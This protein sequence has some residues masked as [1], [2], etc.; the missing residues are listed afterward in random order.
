VVAVILTYRRTEL[1]RRCVD[2]VLGQ[3]RPPDS[4]LVVD[5]DRL[6]RI[7]IADRPGAEV[8]ETGQNLGPAGGYHFGF[9]LA[10]ERGADRI[11]TVDDDLEPGAG[12]LEALLSASS[13]ADVVVPLQ[14]KRT[15]VQG[16][17]PSWNG[18][19]FGAGVVRAVGLPREEFFFWA[20]DTEYFLRIK[21]AGFPVRK[22]NDAT[23]MHWNP[24][25]RF[26]GRR[27]DWRLYYEVRNGLYYRL[28][29][30]PLTRRGVYRALSGALG[31]LVSIVLFE[32]DKVMS[33]RLWLWGV[34]DFL[35]GRLG[36]L[37]D[38]EA[39]SDDDRPR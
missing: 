21:M 33:L 34:R 25:D 1:L 30:H 19:L 16:H 15:K 8:V 27:R 18:A 9:R 11:W 12:C 28:R 13:G 36:K 10:L 17:P 35:R 7:V 3:T 20:E 2:A 37:V 5:N 24:E 14:L 31:K 32:P 22:V 6:A 23:V 4:I 38:P 29:I 26:R 39:W